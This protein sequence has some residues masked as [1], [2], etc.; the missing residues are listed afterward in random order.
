MESTMKES[1]KRSRNPK[2]KPKYRVKNWNQYEGSL[3]NRGNLTVWLYPKAIKSWESKPSG[4]Q[5]RQQKYSDLAIET[6]LTLRLFFHLPLRQAEGF[7]MSLF[8]MMKVPVPIPDH[9][10]LSRRSKTLK[11]SVKTKRNLQTSP[12]SNSWQY[13]LVHSRGMAL[14]EWE[15]AKKRMAK[16]T[17]HG[18]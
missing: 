14:V 11:A 13:R 7:V 2:Y 15:K 8:H 3:R 1:H 6:I 18:G 9:T 10:T 16:A 12:S 17:H 5:G 4:N